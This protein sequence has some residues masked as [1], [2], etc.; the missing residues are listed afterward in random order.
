MLHH[1]NNVIHL[2][3]YI[4]Y[5]KNIV[6]SNSNNQW[7]YNTYALKLQCYVIDLCT[8]HWQKKLKSRPFQLALDFSIVPYGTSILGSKYF[9]IGLIQLEEWPSTGDFATKV[10][11]QNL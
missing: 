8:G 5:D 10:T 4:W 6:T 11:M 9:I 7:L 1:I 3:T 2:L